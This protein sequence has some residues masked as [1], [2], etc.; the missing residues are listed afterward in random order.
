MS[1][2]WSAL[3]AESIAREVHKNQRR[4]DKS[5]YII[6]PEAVAKLILR[7][8]AMDPEVTELQCIAWMHD[9]IEDSKDPEM[10]EKLGSSFHP[11][12]LMQSKRCLERRAKTILILF[13]DAPKTN[14]H[15]KLRSQISPT[16]FKTQNRGQ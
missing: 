12:S 10:E 4:W 2:L 9:V 3:E 13:C 6:H 16:T 5:P 15:E 1:S 14:W 8:H 11:T 7:D